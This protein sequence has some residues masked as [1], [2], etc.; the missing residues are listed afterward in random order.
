VSRNDNQHVSREGIKPL[1]KRVYHRLFPL[2]QGKRGT[3]GAWERV[4]V[5]NLQGG[6]LGPINIVWEKQREIDVLT[7][8]YF[9]LDRLVQRT[10]ETKGS[11][12]VR[13]AWAGRSWLGDTP[14]GN[15]LVVKGKHRFANGG[16]H[17]LLD[18]GHLRWRKQYVSRLLVLDIFRLRT[19]HFFYRRPSY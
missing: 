3:L 5:P 19:Q 13:Q 17:G 18:H 15:V 12:H 9:V 10:V 7:A 4:F 14:R 2:N 16:R 8:E 11:R 6:G 1:V